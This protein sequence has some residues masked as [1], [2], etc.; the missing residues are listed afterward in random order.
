[1]A[2]DAPEPGDEIPTRDETAA[3]PAGE[4]GGP[5]GQS[6]D[7]QPDDDHAEPEPAAPSWFDMASTTTCPACGAAGA[8]ML[9]E[10]VF[11]PTCGEV[12]TPRQPPT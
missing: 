4:P 7:P 8:V 9:G 2:D 10:G 3:A 1:M 6:A 11:C 5:E 12:T